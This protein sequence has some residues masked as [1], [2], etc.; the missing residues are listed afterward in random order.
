MVHL[1]RNAGVAPR[2]VDLQY[3]RPY[4]EASDKKWNKKQI[5]TIA[6]TTGEEDPQ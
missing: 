3:V 4:S 2:H 5:I 6:K 1:I